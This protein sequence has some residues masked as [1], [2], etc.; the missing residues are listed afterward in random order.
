[1]PNTPWTFWR[2]LVIAFL[3]YSH[4]KLLKACASTSQKHLPDGCKQGFLELWFMLRLVCKG[5]SKG[6]SLYSLSLNC[7]SIFFFSKLLWHYLFYAAIKQSLIILSVEVLYFQTYISFITWDWSK[8]F[9]I[10]PFLFFFT[11]LQYLIYSYKT[12]RGKKHMEQNML[13]LV[14]CLPYLL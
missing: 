8:I 5:L 9:L 3:P 2:L 7:A 6:H 14:Y 12:F 1:M 4:F 10:K 13:I 11:L